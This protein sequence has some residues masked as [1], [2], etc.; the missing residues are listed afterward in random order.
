MQK[1]PFNGGREITGN[2]ERW[3]GKTYWVILFATLVL[4]I[5]L[6]ISFFTVLL[7]TGSDDIPPDV[8]NLG[9][10]GNYTAVTK[11]ENKKTGII[12]PSETNG[13]NYL[14]IS[15]QAVTIE[16][17]SSECAILVDIGARASIAE[18]NS[19]IVIHPAS[20]TKIMTLLVACENAKNPNALLTVENEM[21]ER[22]AEL[23]GSGELVENTTA[24]NSEGEAE[25]IEIVGKSVTVADAL[26]LINYQ[27]DTVACLL[28]AE[29]VAGSEAEFVKLMNQKARDIGL[30][31]TNFVNCTG[32][33]EKSGDYNT[34]TCREMA[35]IMACALN[36][37]V[38]KKIIT[39]TEKFKVDVYE[40]TDK[41]EYTIPF[42]ADWHNKSNRLN[43]NVTAG[44][45]KILGGKT[46]YEDIPTS[47][48]VTYGINTST[49]KEY[50]CVTVG[51]MTG[52]TAAI[53]YPAASTSDTR[54][55]YK[56]YAK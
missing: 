29:Y 28:I 50:I 36:N 42:F 46:G 47:C 43:G 23:G 39:S 31:N 48:F 10:N 33:T 54:L 32:L 24:V 52:S 12:L 8:S 37:S 9:N 18:K 16:G 41:T 21:L 3:P 49:S 26:Y 35:A 11:K 14:S 15:D 40:G 30:S 5:A 13:G 22:R 34:T 6:T 38:A 44:G 17:I 20:M 56:N 51:H 53:V 4:L 19:D 55:I 27:S 2:K 25:Q 7:I 45:V 1:N